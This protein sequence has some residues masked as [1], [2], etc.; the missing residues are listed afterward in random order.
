M[1]DLRTCLT[2]MSRAFTLIELLVVI[3]I[4]G[5]LAA[6]LLPALAAAREKAADFVP[7][8][9]QSAGEG[10]GILHRRLRRILPAVAGMGSVPQL[11]LP[12]NPPGRI[13][14]R[15]RDDQSGGRHVWRDY[16][17]LVLLEQFRAQSPSMRSRTVKVDHRRSPGW[18][19]SYQLR[20]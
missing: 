9:P 7:Q 5:I 16:R 4:I 19:P 1:R 10:A 8:Q 11:R 12:R 3:A 13:L 2:R 18:G 20:I 14:L 17:M 6:M 15:H